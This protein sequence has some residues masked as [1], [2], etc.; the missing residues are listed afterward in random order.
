MF[1]PAVNVYKSSTNCV[2]NRNDELLVAS[3]QYVQT[4]EEDTA[5]LEIAH[6]YPTDSGGY[7]C[8][9]VNVAGE[10]SCVAV[11]HVKSKYLRIIPFNSPLIPE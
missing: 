3:E 10:D 8:T 4:F 11:I 9:A 5:T 1:A 2:S 6:P 7:R